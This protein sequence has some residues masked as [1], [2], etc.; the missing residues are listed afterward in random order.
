MSDQL[1]LS[2]AT[3]VEVLDLLF[4]LGFPNPD[5]SGPIGPAGPVISPGPLFVRPIRE[6]F[7]PSS[8]PWG[9][10]PEPWRSI[11]VTR[12]AIDRSVDLL[13]MAG[14]IIVSGDIDR[15]VDAAGM[16]L[17]RFVDDFC[18]TPPHHGPFPGPWGP[19]LDTE[20]LHPV[21]LVLAGA[22]CLKA[23]GALEGHPLQAAI[24]DAAD[25]LLETGLSRLADRG[26]DR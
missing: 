22:Q 6:R 2:K 23:S 20:T 4:I 16:A 14:I 8:E 5:D 26:G 21:N 17:K 12:A 10:H 15:A 1:S 3:F 13:E 24:D 7:G 25:R 19:V 11:A 18:G 9:P